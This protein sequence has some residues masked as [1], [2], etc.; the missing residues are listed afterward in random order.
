LQ[1][2]VADFER[3]DAQVLGI[4]VDS[5]PCHEAWAASLG[6]I[7]FPLL[8]DFHRKV[9][10]RYGLLWKSY[11]MARRAVVILDKSGIVRYIEIFAKGLPDPDR[12]LSVLRVTSRLAPRQ[13]RGPA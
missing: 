4:S 8:S 13:R 7:S 9:C 5:V 3:V 1:A 11:N 6:G 2:R 12:L 10:A